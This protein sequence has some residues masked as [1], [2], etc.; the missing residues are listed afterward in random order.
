[1]TS[2]ISAYLVLVNAATFLVYGI[3]KLKAKRGK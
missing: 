1:M 2:V 3:D